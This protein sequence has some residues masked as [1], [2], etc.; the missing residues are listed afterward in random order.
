MKDLEPILVPFDLI[1]RFLRDPA[2]AG[3]NPHG[4]IRIRQLYALYEQVQE[5]STAD[6]RQTI[7]NHLEQTMGSKFGNTDHYTA[8]HLGIKTARGF[9]EHLVQEFIPNCMRFP[10]TSDGVVTPTSDP[11]EM[12]KLIWQPQGDPSYRS[13]R[14][15]EALTLWSLGH[16]AMLIDRVSQQPLPSQLREL[17]LRLESESN[18]LFCTSS[19][20]PRASV[21][22]SFCNPQDSYRHTEQ[23]TN[24]VVDHTISY[25]HIKV[26]DTYIRVLYHGR[27]KDEYGILRSTLLKS[28]AEIPVARDFC[29][30]TFVFRS[31]KDYLL[32]EPILFERVFPNSSAWMDLRIDGNGKKE[33]NAHSSDHSPPLMQFFTCI[34]GA[35]TEVQI[36]L[37]PNWFNRQCSE[38]TENHH[39]YRLK[40][41]IRLFRLFFPKELYLI[42]WDD[43]VVNEQLRNVQLGR[44]RANRRMEQAP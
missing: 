37:Y 38:G 27:I 14:N 20:L 41:V 19:L 18:G 23:P 9:L 43:T 39:L 1:E 10:F 25:R 31:N 28:K 2:G 11:L 22:Q 33:A 7:A 15:F 8:L 29:G 4:Y 35:L 30:V 5:A 40:Q 12:L 21:I 3:L 13:L 6:G 17:T 44:I 36:F 42:D 16:R 32:A 26:G 34:V 24:V